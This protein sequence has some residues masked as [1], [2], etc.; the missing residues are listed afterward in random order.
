MDK[1]NNIKL[2]GKKKLMIEALITSKGNITKSAEKVGISRLTHYDW[3][4]F[5]P[6]YKSYY[7]GIDD[8]QI[9]FYETALNKLI[10]DKNPTAVIFALKCK[11]KKR[12]WIERQEIDM[13][14]SNPVNIIIE[15]AKDEDTTNK[16]T[17]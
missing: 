7:D 6:V 1:K 13:M 14:N 15:K 10:E 8:Y 17:D 4:E 9:D 16:E 5:D 3:I 11:G 12:G 2:K